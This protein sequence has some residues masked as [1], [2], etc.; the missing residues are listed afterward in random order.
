MNE[1]LSMRP[2]A[3]LILNRNLPDVTDRLVEHVTRFDDDVTDVFVIESGSFE[4]GRSRYRGFVADWP[5]AVEHGLRFA[6]GFNFGLL[7]MEKERNYEHYFLVCQDCLFPDQPTVSI[8]LEE[9]ARYPR[10]GIVSPASPDWGETALIPEGGLRLFWFINL[11]GWMVRGAF[12][13]TVRNDE[14]PSYLD[15]LFDGSN[16]RGYDTD[17]ELVAKAYA[18]D[19]AAGITR[20]AM[21]REDK[22]LT[23][24]MASAMKTDPQ[25]VNRPAMYDEGRRWLRRKYGFNSRW[26]MV[27]YAKAFYNQFFE[28]HP[29]YRELRV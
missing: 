18:N 29:D 22:D 4:E 2:C 17:I 14:A 6:R 5:E 28:H 16:F 24:R 10:L 1:G 8:L 13:E 3:T 15:Y 25:R 12:V 27:T 20:R 23:D 9:M 7:E 11:I 21:F 19:Y 26:N